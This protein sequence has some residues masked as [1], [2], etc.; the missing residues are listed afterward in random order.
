MKKLLAMVLVIML[1]GVSAGCAKSDPA[2]SAL[3]SL[4]P[5]SSA[6]KE[7]AV[8]LTTSSTEPVAHEGVTMKPEDGTLFSGGATFEVTNS[9]GDEAVF[10]SYY[11][12][13]R[14]TGDGQWQ[15]LD[16]ILDKNSIGWES[17]AYIIK[18]NSTWEVKIN[19][20]WL[21]GKLAK[22]NYRLVKNFHFE[23]YSTT[24]S[25]WTEFEIK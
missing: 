17:I 25:V 5:V 13:Q 15:P 2:E 20:E 14:K 1:A 16:Y 21:Y 23:D 22:G 3:V 18:G 24:Y 12:L 6:V 8:S 19:W 11:E 4:G 10:G 7:S 9:T